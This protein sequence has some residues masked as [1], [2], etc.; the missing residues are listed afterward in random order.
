MSQ[1][2]LSKLLEDE[3]LGTSE[4]EISNLVRGVAAA[5]NG[6]GR[7]A[8]LTLLDPLPSPKLRSELETLKKTFELG[9]ETKV[10]S[11]LKISQIRDALRESNLDGVMVPRTD[12]YQGEYVSAR[13]QRVAWLTGFTGSA[14]TV[15]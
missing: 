8:W 12:E 2:K 1:S 4:I 15:I 5:P 13:A 3:G 9:F 7:D 11:L 14:G 6:F 10:D